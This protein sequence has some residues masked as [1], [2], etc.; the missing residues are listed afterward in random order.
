MAVA[1]IDAFWDGLTVNFPDADEKVLVIA[2]IV[3]KVKIV[4]DSIPDF[5]ADAQ[6]QFNLP[7]YRES[8]YVMGNGMILANTP[9]RAVLRPGNITN[10]MEVM[11]GDIEWFSALVKMQAKLRDVG[12]LVL[13]LE[14][15]VGK[16]A[17]DVATTAAAV[18]A[19]I[20]VTDSERTKVDTLIQIEQI[21]VSQEP[22]VT[23]S[24]TRTPSFF[25]SC[26]SLDVCIH[27]WPAWVFNS[28]YLKEEIIDK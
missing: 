9:I 8:Y 3:A 20:P 6:E 18:S 25:L 5:T 17:Q 11:V 27:V 12:K 2:T 28:S 13:G 23:K 24:P 15:M 4:I 22:L 10:T 16:S 21:K 7:I 1:A 14:T 26:G 19:V